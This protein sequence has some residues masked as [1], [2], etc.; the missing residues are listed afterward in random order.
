MYEFRDKLFHTHAKDLKI[1]RKALNAKGA[2]A[3]GWE[4]PKLPGLGDVN[5]NAWISAL[6]DVGYQGTVSVEVEDDA[7]RHELSRRKLSLRI[8]HDVLRP[9]IGGAARG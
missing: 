3:I 1:D 5:W 9:L 8:S 7:F 4:V 2:F 6:T